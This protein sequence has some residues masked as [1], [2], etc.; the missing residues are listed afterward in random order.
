MSVRYQICFFFIKYRY[1]SDTFAFSIVTIG[2]L[3]I[4]YCYIRVKA[5]FV[6][7]ILSFDKTLFQSLSSKIS[8]F[9]LS[10]RYQILSNEKVYLQLK[11]G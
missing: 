3:T 7:Y 6:W 5:P 9:I 2:I 8:C 10:V 1:V 11:Y 4:D